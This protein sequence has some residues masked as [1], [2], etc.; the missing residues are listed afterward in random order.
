MFACILESTERAIV[1]HENKQYYPDAEAVYGKDVEITVQDEDTQ[2]I[3][4]PIVETSKQKKFD[5]RETISDLPASTYT[6]E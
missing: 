2:P 3:S 1:L 4:K 6:K 5:H